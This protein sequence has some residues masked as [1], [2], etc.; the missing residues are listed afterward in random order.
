MRTKNLTAIIGACV[1]VVAG[2][3]AVA[4]PAKKADPASLKN[5]SPEEQMQVCMQACMEA[6]TPGPEH[7]HL[8]KGVGTWNGKVTMYMPGMDP[9]VNQCVTT[10]RPS[11][12]GRFVQIDSK[13]D[14]GEMGPFEGHGICGYDNVAKT[15]QS[16]WYDCMGT[17]M[18]IGTGELSSDG[19]TM[20]WTL[21]F[22]CPVTKQPTQMKQIERVTGP[23]SMVL[24]MHAP[25]PI[26]GEISKVMDIEYTRDH[27]QA[28]ATG[29]R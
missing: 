18:A 27:S 7:A 26:T 3:A 12:D 19:M 24:E 5:L 11:V 16:V 23:D 14:M 6:A 8:A 9:I 22:N 20:T 21:T 17:G 25:N 1:L 13:G 28:A 29:T 2:S 10:V 15:Y 4:Q